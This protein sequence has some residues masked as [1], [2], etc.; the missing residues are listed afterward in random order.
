MTRRK[1]NAAK[2]RAKIYGFSEFL[3]FP[4]RVQRQIYTIYVEQSYIRL[5]MEFKHPETYFN[6][7][8]LRIKLAKY[9]VKIFCVFNFR[10]R[11]CEQ[12]VLERP[13]FGFTQT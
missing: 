1:R 8:K 13:K 4:E 3:D 9:I 11:T 7:L 5:L 6:K 10:I 2:N 12:A